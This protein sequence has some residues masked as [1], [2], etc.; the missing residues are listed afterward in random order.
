VSLAFLALLAFH[1]G[2]SDLRIES[3]ERLVGG[4]HRPYLWAPIAVTVS[5]GSGFEGDL[6]VESS[7]GLRI[8]R[9]IHVPAN[10]RDRLVLPA[11]DPKK[12]VA[13]GVT[14]L[15]PQA[16]KSP[17]VVVLVDAQLPYA[18]EL[19]SDDRVLYQTIDRAD[20]ERLLSQGL[21]DACDLVLVGNASGL[22]LG[23][24]RAWAVAPSRADA[25]RALSRKP[26][27]VE[28]VRWVDLELWGLAPEGD[29]VPA[30]KDRALLFAALYALAGFASLVF[31][32]RRHPKWAAAVIAAVAALGTGAFLIFFPRQHLW[33]SENGC[34]VVPAEGDALRMR[35]WFAGAGTELS[36]TIDFP[37]VVKPV[38]ARVSHAEEPMTIR[39]HERGCTVE[40]FSL[41][42]GRRVCFSGVEGRAPTMRATER[43][44]R[45]L[46]GAS[47]R[48]G[49]TERR[50][51][52]LP[53]G[54][55]IPKEAGGGTS[56]PREG[57]EA[58]WL[59]FADGDALW[60]WLDRETRPAEDVGSAD[61]ADGRRRPTFFIQRFR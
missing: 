8:V 52:D 7:L 59:R 29:W 44:A 57:G 41:P 32:G 49:G 14:A 55:E 1:P 26:G 31:L 47:M 10:G 35:L 40:G 27:S 58:P 42:S 48:R 18:S 12:V 60:G 51:G 56:A 9:R 30:K 54:S 21:V 13:G 22:S 45:P 3:I 19:A 50:L 28:P 5:S 6:V 17:D 23:S 25:D 24:A 53:A 38:F 61:L 16:V 46:L 34:E 33:I 20:L 11:L 2:P 39:L 15:V 37:R 4:A 36:P 43:V